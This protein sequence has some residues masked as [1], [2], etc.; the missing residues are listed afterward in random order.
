MQDGKELLE[1]TTQSGIHTLM[2]QAEEVVGTV[3][4]A[5][6]QYP[7]ALVHF[8]KAR[9]LADTQIMRS[10]E[11]LDC[12]DTLWR[13]GRYAESEALLQTIAGSDDLVT[14]AGQT[15]I[16]SLLS[17]QQYRLA[18]A[19]AQQMIAEYP[20]MVSD[21]KLELQ[22]DEVLAES[23]LGMK[24][25]ALLDLSAYFAPEQHKDSPEDAA[26]EELS[27]AEIY[28]SLGMARQAH[29]SAVAAH[30]YFA[31]SGQLNSELRSACLA[32]A[33]SKLLNDLAEYD[34]FSTKVVDIVTALQH[35]WQPQDLQQYLLRPDLHL[36]T[37]DF[38]KA[39][40]INHIRS[41]T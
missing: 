27:A 22:Q 21:R 13:L 3:H 32:A 19:L 39:G 9:S 16:E 28:L 12:A 41:K 35:T 20:K 17:Q 29:D 10:Y 8:Q 26:K 38:A 37:R 14:S 2:I 36:L 7:E 1:V 23:H 4:F 18:L 5:V 33:A 34:I 25:Q 15:R 31:S 6:E 11:A 30:K 40:Q 24:K